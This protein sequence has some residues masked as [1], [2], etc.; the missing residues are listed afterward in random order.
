[1]ALMVVDKPPD[2]STQTKPQQR[3]LDEDTYIEVRHTRIRRT[4]GS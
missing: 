4:Q 3:V 2:T 1:M